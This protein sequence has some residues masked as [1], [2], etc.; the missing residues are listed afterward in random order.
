MSFQRMPIRLKRG[1]P[2]VRKHAVIQ[3]DKN[4]TLANCSSAVGLNRLCTAAV[5]LGDIRHRPLSDFRN[6]LPR[7]PRM[8]WI[9]SGADRFVA[10]MWG[11]CR[12]SDIAMAI[13]Q[14]PPRH[15]TSNGSHT[16]SSLPVMAD[17]CPYRPAATAI[18]GQTQPFHGLAWLRISR[19]MYRQQPRH[20]VTRLPL[21]AAGHTGGFSKI[22]RWFFPV[23]FSSNLIP[24]HRT[25]P[26]TEELLLL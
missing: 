11:I 12:I 19:D 8:G 5:V 15:A 23:V 10:S 4:K 20:Q 1:R 13:P 9:R 16:N 2:T 21:C 7:I 3:A 22:F 24:K 6:E 17:A 18:L 25:P 14:A 26:C